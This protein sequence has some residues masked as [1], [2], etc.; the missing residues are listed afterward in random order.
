MFHLHIQETPAGVAHYAR[1]KELKHLV[2]TH[3]PTL[4]HAT[5]SQFGPEMEEVRL[6]CVFVCFPLPMHV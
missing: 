3:P 6:V 5:R 2:V 4:Y 1:Y